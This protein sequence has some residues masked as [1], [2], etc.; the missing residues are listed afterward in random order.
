MWKTPLEKPKPESLRA[1][2]HQNNTDIYLFS[3]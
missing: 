2:I 1:K 3:N